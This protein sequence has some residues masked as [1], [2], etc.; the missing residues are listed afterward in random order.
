MSEH[1]FV[2]F[3]VSMAA[4][5]AAKMER[6]RGDVARSTFVARAVEQHLDGLPHVPA[7]KRATT[8]AEPPGD[9]AE[10]D[11]VEVAPGGRR[12]VHQPGPN[13]ENLRSSAQAKRGVGPV[14][15][16]GKR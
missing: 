14:P 15:K 13:V 16:G 10:L 4:P 1:G 8:V 12:R 6:V 9:K 11:D 3:T 5:L 2:K 7:H